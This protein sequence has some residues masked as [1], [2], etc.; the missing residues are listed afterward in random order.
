MVSPVNDQRKVVSIQKPQQVVKPSVNSIQVKNPRIFGVTENRNAPQPT[1]GSLEVKQ[2]TTE[3]NGSEDQQDVGQSLRQNDTDS[4]SSSLLKS[5]TTRPV[6]GMS[7][8]SVVNGNSKPV[9]KSIRPKPPVVQQPPPIL[10][11]MLQADI[12]DQERFEGEIIEEP[13]Q[14]EDG[15]SMVP[16][17]SIACGGGQVPGLL[18]FRCLCLFHTTCVPNGLC[19]PNDQ[20]V[21][22]NC[23]QPTDEGRKVSEANQANGGDS[24]DSD[25]QERNSRQH[26]RLFSRLDPLASQKTP[27]LLQAHLTKNK[28]PTIIPKPSSSSPSL[29]TPMMKQRQKSH[30]ELLQ[31]FQQQSTSKNFLA[32]YHKEL[33]TAKQNSRPRINAD[34]EGIL[35]QKAQQP[36]MRSKVHE[37]LVKSGHHTIKYPMLGKPVAR[38]SNGS[39]S[40][41]SERPQ[42]IMSREK[43][44]QMSKMIHS[45]LQSL[46]PSYQPAPIAPIAPIKVTPAQIASFLDKL[47]G[48][49]YREYLEKLNSPMSRLLSGFDVLSHC[50]EYLDP[51]D[52]ANL[53]RVN[54]SFKRLVS[55]SEVWQRMHEDNNSKQGVQEEEN[56]TQ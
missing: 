56:I 55:N 44:Q 42:G 26:S 50:L 15:K 12:K 36:L 14:G 28:H 11:Q 49:R 2:E 1:E 46:A 16:P 24:S 10:Q 47:T 21:C 51:Q 3:A 54:R 30:L 13:Y 20:F 31:Q 35:P 48:N 43:H 9:F 45:Q 8:S 41:G 17:C 5:K 39:Q 23:I 52:L 34:H 37:F 40:R 33:A 32:S 53:M 22:P 18:C 6:T 25:H 7:P 29:S 4:Q 38:S 27:S 19:L